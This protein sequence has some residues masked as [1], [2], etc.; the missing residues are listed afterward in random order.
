MPPTLPSSQDP[1]LNLDL[2]IHSWKKAKERIQGLEVKLV[3][4]IYN[5]ARRYIKMGNMKER[6][7]DM[8]QC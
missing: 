8:K 3:K 5:E 2:S 1:P 7:R 4:I 6:L